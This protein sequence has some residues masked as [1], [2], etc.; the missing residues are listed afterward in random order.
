MSKLPRKDQTLLH[1]HRTGKC[2]RIGA[3]QQVIHIAAKDQCRWCHNAVESVYHLCNERRCPDV[4]VDA[5][6]F[7]LSPD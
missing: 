6:R 2:R 3:F 5:L 1:Q 7:L 4:N